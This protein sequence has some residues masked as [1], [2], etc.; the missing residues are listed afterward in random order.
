M[1]L[2]R[3]I[4]SRLAMSTSHPRQCAAR[5]VAIRTPKGPNDPPP[6]GIGPPSEAYAGVP[7][8]SDLVP[9]KSGF[10]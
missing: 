4:E 6:D 2:E 7:E 8:K 1:G 3:A 10:L 9:E 5:K